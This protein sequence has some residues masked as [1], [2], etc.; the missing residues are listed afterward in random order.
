[1]F[2]VDSELKIELGCLDFVMVD[3]LRIL[4][5]ARKIRQ[6]LRRDRGLSGTRGA[7]YFD[8]GN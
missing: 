5:L 4:S 6:W 7:N 8:I 1:V 2:F 3:D